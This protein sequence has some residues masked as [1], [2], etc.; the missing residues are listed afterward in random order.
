LMAK[1]ARIESAKPPHESL[2]GWPRAT[3]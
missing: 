3:P 2:T 1:R